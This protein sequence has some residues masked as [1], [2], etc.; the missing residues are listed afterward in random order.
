MALFMVSVPASAEAAGKR[1]G[2]PEFDGAQGPVVR[3]KVMQ[4]L[5][6]HGFELVR[7]SD[8]LE[9]M[10]LDG[11]GLESDDDLETL[12]KELALSAVVTGEV[13]PRRA[14]IFVRDG[15]DG[16]ILGDASF[17]GSNPR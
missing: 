16:S 17:S 10:A 8:L 13:G 7:S 2:V 12:A 6:A 9:A 3:A 15:A 1:I 14:K 11:I 4:V 5:Q